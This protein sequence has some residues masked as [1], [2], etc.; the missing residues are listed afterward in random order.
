[1][2]MKKE[3]QILYC[4]IHITIT[5]ISSY[6]SFSHF[7]IRKIT[8]KDRLKWFGIDDLLVHKI[9][10]ISAI[11]VSKSHNNNSRLTY[12]LT[13]PEIHKLYKAQ[14]VLEFDR[15]FLDDI[16]A[17]LLALRLYRPGDIV[18]PI[19]FN[20]EQTL[21]QTTGTP[22]FGKDHSIYSITK[23]DITKINYLFNLIKKE[24]GQPKIGKVFERYRYAIDQN[25]SNE[26]SFIELVSILESLFLNTNSEL[27]YRFSLITSYILMKKLKLYA[28]F[29]QMKNIYGIRSDLIHSGKIISRKYIKIYSEE[30]LMTL[31]M[32]V[33]ELLMWYLKNPSYRSDPETLIINTLGTNDCILQIR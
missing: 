26:T 17:L 20:K 16:P 7:K 8:N 22:L 9:G 3:N 4:P 21:V 25:T 13:D 11:S 5:D 12:L 27:T 6:S 15:N 14:F 18:A 30:L 1:M 32:Y 2:K 24:A 23:K 33:S 19:I 28:P 29:S 31:K 10:S